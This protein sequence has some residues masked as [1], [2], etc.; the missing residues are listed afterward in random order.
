MI[1]TVSLSTEADPK[2]LLAEIQA[3]RTENAELKKS[4]E[5]LRGALLGFFCGMMVLMVALLLDTR[6]Q[7]PKREGPNRGSLSLL[8][9][10]LKTLMAEEEAKRFVHLHFGKTG[11]AILY[12]LGTATSGDDLF[13]NIVIALRR[14]GIA[15]GILFNALIAFRPHQREYIRRVEA[16]YFARSEDEDRKEPPVW[17]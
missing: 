12:S 8:F 7:E 10:L 3:L 1:R 2:L 6:T 11:E 15:N 9:G 17:F 4:V 16:E 5:W 13:Y 14:Q